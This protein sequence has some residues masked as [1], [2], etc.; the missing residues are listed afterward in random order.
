VR[1]APKEKTRA[2]LWK[3]QVL[4]FD[5]ATDEKAPAK[6]PLPGTIGLGNLGT[7]G[8][9]GKPARTEK[10]RG[11]GKIGKASKRA[12][13]ASAPGPTDL[14]L[15]GPPPEAPPARDA[16]DQAPADDVPLTPA[17]IKAALRDGKLTRAEVKTL[18]TGDGDGSPPGELKLKVARIR[19]EA[20]R[21]GR[22]EQVEPEI[23]AAVPPP[24][25]R[26]P[27]DKA[28]TAR[29]KTKD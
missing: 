1:A 2:R 27:E 5:L 19:A 29:R 18:L 25:K 11:T 17:E 14:A 13:S 21:A 16:S 26:F 10:I 7:I 23:K 9:E 4:P 28:G 3:K 20:R 24:P 12:A 15:D 22:L 6:A 8:K